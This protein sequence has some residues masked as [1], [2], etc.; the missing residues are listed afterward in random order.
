MWSVGGIWLRYRTPWLWRCALWRSRCVVANPNVAN[1]GQTDSQ[2]GREAAS[3]PAVVAVAL[4]SNRDG[5][6]ADADARGGAGWDL[7][8]QK[9]R[10]P[11]VVT[12]VDRDPGGWRHE[13]KLA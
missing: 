5:A 11:E 13:T 6:S 7:D 9:T 10:A 4:S 12:L 2:A 1:W 3:R 8:V